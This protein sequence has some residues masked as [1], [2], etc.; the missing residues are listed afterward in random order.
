M[1]HLLTFVKGPLFA[2]TFLFMLLGLGRHVLLQIHLLT[3]KGKKL[4]LV[5]WKTLAVESLSWA[6]PLKHLVNGTILLSA[7]SIL[8]HIGAILVPVFLSEH[9]VL[10]ENLLNLNIP[11]IGREF[12]DFLTILTMLCILILLGYRLVIPRSRALSKLSDYFLLILIFLPF[13]SGFLAVHPA[14]NP[15]PWENMM[16]IHIVSAECLFVV[17][18]FSKLA[19]IVL[20]PFDRLSQVHWQ[21]KPGAGEKVA[22]AILGEEVKV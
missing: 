16:L 2:A 21:L 17:I 10:W 9:I 15:L 13:S 4:R 6:L 5:R 1:G 19:H 8:F 3:S 14:F 12:A 18:P 20:F 22:S 11:S 7:T